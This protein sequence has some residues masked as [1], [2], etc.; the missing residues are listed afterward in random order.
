M[1][2]VINILEDNIKS[3]S[4]FDNI[5]YNFKCLIHDIPERYL[6]YID[7]RNLKESDNGSIM[8]LFT[9]ELRFIS[10]EVTDTNLNI[11]TNVLKESTIALFTSRFGV[12]DC[13]GIFLELLKRLYT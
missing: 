13:L 8:F 5:K 2:S 1:I 7:F 6:M 9:N 10:I 3:F 12:S 4:I 11:E